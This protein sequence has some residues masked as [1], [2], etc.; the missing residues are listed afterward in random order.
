MT[1]ES[2]Q[3]LPR[4]FMPEMVDQNSEDSEIAR[5]YQDRAVFITGGTGFIGKVLLEKLLRSCP[6]LKRA[7]LLVRSK[8]GEEPRARLEMMFNSEMFE[9]L[10]REQ[11]D[12]LKKVI[13]LEGDLT[14][15]NLG[16][17][18]SDQ[19]L[20]TDDVSVVFHS[21][22]TVKFDEP[23]R[24]AVE[25]N[26]FG[27]RR[28]LDLC[29]RMPKLCAFVH[30][31]TAYCNCDK[32]DVQE[33][34]YPPPLGSEK[35]IKAIEC[36]DK[37]AE[38]CPQSRLFGHPNTYTLTKS[39]AE[40][41]LL[42]ERGHT[43]VSI[44]RPSI[45]TAAMN[46]PRPIFLNW[47]TYCRSK[48]VKVFHCT[49]G[50][51]KPLTRAEGVRMAKKNVLRHPLPGTIGFPKFSTTNIKLWHQLKLWGL[52]YVPAC[53]IDLALQL[54]GRKPRFVRRY[55]KVGKAVRVVE[56]FTT[57]GWLFRM[58]NVQK[59]LRELSRTDAKAL[60]YALSIPSTA[61]HVCLVATADEHSVE[62]VL[63]RGDLCKNDV[64]NATAPTGYAAEVV[65]RT[66]TT[67]YFD[68][69]LSSS[70]P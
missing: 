65:T 22:A 32:P 19:A 42:E 12:A 29:K 47:I 43:P 6:G 11:P 33:V 69:N 44:V 62:L 56:Y 18:L 3:Q 53:L 24:K 66:V 68:G 17:S 50:A 36:A 39:L 51:V 38:R 13:A 15:P 20:L 57:N 70:G 46:E 35:V 67:N 23:I 27:T 55:E 49:S 28:V 10:K 48:Q 31:S 8:R 7:Y 60:R 37:N 40:S 9:G 16:L 26:V 21:G 1:T 64:P 25:L 59:L 2:H 45:V 63:L 5:F 41:L 30:V 4:S 58:N 34:I 14:Q 52:H 61:A 54:C